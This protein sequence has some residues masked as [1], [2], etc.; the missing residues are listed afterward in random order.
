[1]VVCSM[2][3]HPH[4]ARDSNARVSV[5]SCSAPSVGSPSLPCWRCGRG[6][7]GREPDP[8]TGQMER[9]AT[10]MFLA[11]VLVEF[12]KL[13]FAVDSVPAIFAITTDP[14]IVYTSRR[15]VRAALDE[16][17]IRTRGHF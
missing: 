4:T 7:P 6:P 15:R 16:A 12:V 11:L 17:R 1:M 14:F 5:R 2:L 8:K 13:I 10:P 3:M 9:F